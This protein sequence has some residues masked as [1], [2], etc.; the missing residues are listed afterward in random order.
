MAAFHCA[1]EQWAKQPGPKTLA[2]LRS[3]LDTT[4][5]AASQAATYTGAAAVV[6]GGGQA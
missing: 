6:P 3:R 1:V 2:G 4:L 5:D